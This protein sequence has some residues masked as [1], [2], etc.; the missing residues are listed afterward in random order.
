M[1]LLAV[2]WAVALVA[3][4]DGLRTSNSGACCLCVAD[5]GD[6]H[7]GGIQH[8]PTVPGVPKLLRLAVA[9]SVSDSLRRVD[10]DCTGVHCTPYHN[11][12]KG[13]TPRRIYLG[14]HECKAP[15]QLHAGDAAFPVPSGGKANS[16]GGGED[17]CP[18]TSKDA[19]RIHG[20]LLRQTLSYLSQH[21]WGKEENQ[22]TNLGLLAPQYN[23]FRD[24]L[25]ESLMRSHSCCAEGEIDGEKLC[26]LVKHLDDKS[27]VHIIPTVYSCESPSCDTFGKF[28]EQLVKNL[29]EPGTKLCNALDAGEPS[30]GAVVGSVLKY[31]FSRSD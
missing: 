20:M 31:L 17:R 21:E 12:E 30:V 8:V 29:A 26:T 27:Q 3:V 4:S 7:G 16:S 2:A 11:P 24:I 25:I 19:P 13:K 6:E 10:V 14:P 1:A 18:I 22:E 23:K 5:G 15:L 9:R 28:R